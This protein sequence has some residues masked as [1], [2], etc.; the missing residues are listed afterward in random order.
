MTSR[1][2]L[3]YSTVFSAGLRV[4]ESLIALGITALLTRN[5]GPGLYGEYSTIFAVL[6]TASLIA[7]FGLRQILVREL[8]AKP[9]A[10]KIFSEIVTLRLLTTAAAI[11][12]AI[13]IS[14]FIPAYTPRI[15]WGLVIGL[16]IT[17]PLSLTQVLGGAFQ[18]FFRFERVG[19]AETAGRALQLGGI[20]ALALLHRDGF[21]NFLITAAAGSFLTFIV[22]YGYLRTLLRFRLTFS[23]ERT[24]ELLREAWPIAVSLLSVLI[25]FKLDTILLSLLKPGYDVGLYNVAYKVFE[26]VLFFPALVTGVVLPLLSGRIGNREGFH[27]AFRRTF[28]VMVALA[29]PAVVGIIILA[30]PLIQLIAG[31][32]FIEAVPALQILALALLV[33]FPAHLFGNAIIAITKQ[34]ESMYVY[35][36]GAAINVAANLAVIPRYSFIGASW[37]TLATEIFVTVWLGVILH[38]HGYLSF[39]PRYLLRPLLAAGV[40]AGALLLF[41][42]LPLLVLIPLGVVVYGVSAY[43]FKVA[44][45]EE[46]REILSY[47]YKS[48]RGDYT[49]GSEKDVS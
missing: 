41:T 2:R 23:F 9:T 36:T 22:A 34:R 48:S 42:Y 28:E 10:E 7:D 18:H 25:Y 44:E 15:K 40:M 21:Y 46:V 1:G 8:A 29:L 26:N 37:T 5:L 17:I 13:V 16:F 33:V 12:L 32:E 49:L 4:V 20:L 31:T 24:K 43:I 14:L 19:V 11:V 27:R 30:A 45:K 38:R 35:M 3:V 39:S 47:V 6:F